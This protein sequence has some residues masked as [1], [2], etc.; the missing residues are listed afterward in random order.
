MGKQINRRGLGA[1]MV[2]GTLGV[3][4]GSIVLAGTAS[5]HGIEVDGQAYMAIKVAT[6]QLTA[7]GQALVTL[8]DGSTHSL[9]AGDFQIIDG[10][11]YALES[12]VGPDGS[13]LLG[14]GLRPCGGLACVAF[15][16][17]VNNAASSPPWSS[18]KFVLR[19]CALAAH[20]AVALN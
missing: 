19:V 2:A 11:F 1:S 10:Q 8:S 14:A 18:D 5:A 3:A 20:H 12:L 4:A 17:V 9:A 16:F 15:G 7:D 13:G 6:W